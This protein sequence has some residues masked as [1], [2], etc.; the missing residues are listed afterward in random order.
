MIDENTRMAE[1]ERWMAKG[2]RSERKHEQEASG[3]DG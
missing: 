1:G 2:E 3:S